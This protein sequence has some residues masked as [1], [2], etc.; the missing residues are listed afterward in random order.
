MA[1]GYSLSS[2]LRAPSPQKRRNQVKPELSIR[3]DSGPC[4]HVLELL[5]A[6][7]TNDNA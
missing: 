5:L 1:S 2:S 6:P 7:G 4:I 3:C